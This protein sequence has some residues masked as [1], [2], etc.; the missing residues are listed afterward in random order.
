MAR[1]FGSYSPAVPLGVTWEEK[2]TYQDGTGTAI[3]I[4]GY[5]VRAQLF[6]EVPGRAADDPDPD[7]VCEITTAGF[8]GATP[9]AW[10]VFEGFTVPAGTDGVINMR[11]DVDDL[12]RLSP[13][14]T[15]RKLRWSVVLVGV[16]DYTLPVVQGV[17]VLLQARTQQ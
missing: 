14:N 13:D 12:W 8:Y 11:I 7:P 10:P 5:A 9:P 2:F 15:K 17:V 6:A 1:Q 4:T 3:D 16:A